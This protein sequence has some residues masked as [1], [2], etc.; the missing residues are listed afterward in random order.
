MKISVVVPVYHNAES[1]PTLHQR[2]ADVAAR[3]PQSEFEF[4]FVDD[5]SKDNSFGVLK[6]LAASDPRVKVLRL[7]RNFG[8]NAAILAGLTYARGDCTAMITADLQDPPELIV[9][10][11]ERWRAGAKVVLAA[12]SERRDPFLTR[13]SGNAFN[14][15]FRQLVFPNFPPQGFDFWLA[16]KEVIDN[17]VK[18]AG[19]NTYVMGLL[20]WLGYPMETVTYTR[21]DRLFGKSQWTLGK[22]IKYF[23]DAFVGFSY[24][25]LRLG[26][27]VGIALA[28][29]GFLYAAFVIVAKIVYGFPA[30]GWTSLMVVMLLVS[31]TQLVMLGIVGE[32]VWRNLDEA[33]QRPL[34]LVGETVGVKTE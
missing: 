34:F 1:L 29:L 24:L 27:V 5:G 17:L 32:Y 15:L 3:I 12:R 23:L 28:I 4:L 19:T 8:S 21:G 33:R 14:W 20:L 22:K 30:E 26:S 13:I 11:I 16:D 25:P 18:T 10:M 2:L 6:N 9:D 31:G 7:V